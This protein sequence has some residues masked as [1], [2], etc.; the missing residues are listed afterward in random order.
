MTGERA[1]APTFLRCDNRPEMTAH[2][3]RGWCRFSRAGSAYIEP[4]SPWQN[5]WRIDHNQRRPQSALQMMTPAALAG[6]R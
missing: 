5:A 6:D 2:A 1:T 3:L 4:G